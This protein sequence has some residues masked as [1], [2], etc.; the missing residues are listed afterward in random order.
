M[1]AA[2]INKVPAG[3]TLAIDRNE[4]LKTVTTALENHPFII[5]KHEGI[6]KILKL[7]NM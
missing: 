5:I 1:K 3:R 7:G 6:Q 4:F 2:D